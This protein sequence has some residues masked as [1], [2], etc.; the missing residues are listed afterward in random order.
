MAYIIHAGDI[1]ERSLLDM[2]E[3]VAP[4]IAVKGNADILKLPE[5][6]I[7]NIRDKRVLVIHGHNF[8]TLD[9]QNLL[10]KGLEEEADIVIFGHTHRPYYAKLK[11]MGKE[12]TLLNPGSPTLPRMSEPTFAILNIG[13][14]VEVKFYN[15][16]ML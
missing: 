1:T 10:Y 13:E 2:L 3:N 11:Y 12:I 6:E 9:T 5:E 15:V 7:L 16:W 14:S 4:V 8:L